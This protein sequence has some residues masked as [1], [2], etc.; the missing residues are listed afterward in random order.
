MNDNQSI[1]GTD[2]IIIPDYSQSTPDYSSL[3]KI[4]ETLLDE[5]G[6]L[7]RFL[8][9]ITLGQVDRQT[10]EQRATPFSKRVGNLLKVSVLMKDIGDLD[11]V[12]IRKMDFIPGPAL[13]IIPDEL[14]V[15]DDLINVH[16]TRLV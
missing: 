12:F 2:R 11:D 1:V 8:D 16:L 9:I 15:F 5:G 14:Q 6:I 3:E 13:I 4:V 7:L 10:F